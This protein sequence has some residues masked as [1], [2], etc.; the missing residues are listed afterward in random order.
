V[1]QRLLAAH[2]ERIGGSAPRLDRLERLADNVS[3]NLACNL[4]SGVSARMTLA[5][6]SVCADNLSL[7]LTLAPPRARD[8]ES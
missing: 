5:G 4:A 8:R 6:V 1:L 7:T 2:I 3:Y